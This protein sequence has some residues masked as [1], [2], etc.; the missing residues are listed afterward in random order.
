MKVSHAIVTVRLR[1]L[2]KGD[3]VCSFKGS[4]AQRTSL[5]RYN[6]LQKIL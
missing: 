1:D 6:T 2:P 3:V 4:K 5:V